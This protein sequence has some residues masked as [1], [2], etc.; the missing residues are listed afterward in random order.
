[1]HKEFHSFLVFLQC[2]ITGALDALQE[3]YDQAHEQRELQ[4]LCAYEIGKF[5]CL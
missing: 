1:L 2:D 3:S 5:N 4:L